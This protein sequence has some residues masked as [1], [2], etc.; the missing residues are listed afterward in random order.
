MWTDGSDSQE[1]N[2]IL[3]CGSHFIDVIRPAQDDAGFPC[4][5]LHGPSRQGRQAEVEREMN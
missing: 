1:S 4:P 2:E 3:T 5:A